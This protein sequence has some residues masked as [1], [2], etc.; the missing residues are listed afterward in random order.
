M[1]QLLE[2]FLTVGKKSF[3]LKLA[4]NTHPGSYQQ[5]DIAC[6]GI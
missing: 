5:M 2:M 1:S 6:L 4:F 3:E